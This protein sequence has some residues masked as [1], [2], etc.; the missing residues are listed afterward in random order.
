MSVLCSA[1]VATRVDLG[2]ASA[3]LVTVH[4][5]DFLEIE[6]GYF[7][8]KDLIDIAQFGL[9][10]ALEAPGLL[11]IAEVTDLVSVQHSL[12]VILHKEEVHQMHLVDKEAFL[13]ETA[14]AAKNEV[15]V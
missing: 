12:P 10:F 9:T 4:A 7:P 15:V 11:P 8:A 13:L 1:V 14:L 5:H 2:K 6:K 3:D